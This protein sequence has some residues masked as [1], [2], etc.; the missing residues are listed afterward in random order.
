MDGYLLYGVIGVIVLLGMGGLI[1]HWLH[2]QGNDP[3]LHPDATLPR[4]PTH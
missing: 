3:A 4:R 2:R 1:R